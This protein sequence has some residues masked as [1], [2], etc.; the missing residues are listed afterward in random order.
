FDIQ[1]ELCRARI[2][3]MGQVTEVKEVIVEQNVRFT[4]LDKQEPN[5]QPLL[6]TG[7]RL[8]ALMPEP[9][10]AVVTVNG[11]P[12]H[13]EARGLTLDSEAIHLDRGA[14]PSWTDSGGVMTLPMDR[15][16]EGKPVAGNGRLEVT[17][18][19]QMFF[20]GRLARFTREVVAHQGPRT[21][22][23]QLLKVNF[24]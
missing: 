24:A 5:V 11:Q 6:V 2:K 19:G 3:I 1:G 22:R 10:A 17:W 14:N 7:Q 15:D 12:A 9:Q 16:L 23:T 13:V 21:M 8:H 4:E 20:D 18:Q